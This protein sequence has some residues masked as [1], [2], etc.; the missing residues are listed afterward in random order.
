VRSVEEKEA[1]PIRESLHIMDQGRS[2]RCKTWGGK[3]TLRQ[4]EPG[5][6]ERPKKKGDVARGSSEGKVLCLY[7]DNGRKKIAINSSLSWLAVRQCD[8]E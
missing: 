3:N 5:G 8:V 1:P 7:L 6:G 4:G 2:R